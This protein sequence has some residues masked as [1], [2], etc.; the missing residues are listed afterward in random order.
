MR[1]HF[2]STICHHLPLRLSSFSF[3]LVPWSIPLPSHSP[4]IP[5]SLSIPSSYSFSPSTS[6]TCPP[7]I[8]STSLPSSSS[9]VSHSAP[10]SF[11]IPPSSIVDLSIPSV[12]TNLIASSRTY[13]IHSMVTRFKAGIYKPK[14]LLSVST[15]PLIEPTSFHQAV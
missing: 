6:S 14:L 11:P 2:H 9:F 13:N 5:I 4:S 7:I 3:L 12:D 15:S 1:I 10:S 8:A